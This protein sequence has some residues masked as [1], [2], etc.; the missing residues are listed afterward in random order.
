MLLTILLM[1]QPALA[2]TSPDD[3]A[4]NGAPAVQPAK[5][6]EQLEYLALDQSLLPVRLGRVIFDDPKMRDE[7]KRVGL[8]QGCVAVDQ[9]RKEIGAKYKPALVPPTVSAIRKVVPEPV[10]T[11]ATVLAFFSWPLSG[12]KSRIEDELEV[13]ASEILQEA[14]A[15]M[16]V[17]FL[18][19]TAQFPTSRNRKDNVLVPSPHLAAALSIEGAY[20]L[21]KPEA[22]NM[23]CV[24]LLTPKRPRSET[25]I[26][27]PP[28]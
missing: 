28:Q 3:V 19:Q 27:P 1:L 10:L 9:S 18:A 24:D 2:P 14:Y 20:D 26:E 7:I 22:M 11:E 6:D 13:T 8:R 15:A 21:N 5:T 16:R 12:Y 25:S 4:P 17:E 23:A